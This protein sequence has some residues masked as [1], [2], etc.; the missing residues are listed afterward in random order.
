MSADESLNEKSLS[1]LTTEIDQ[2][3]AALESNELPLEEA[4]RRY[5]QGMSLLKVAQSKLNAAEQQVRLLD[6]ALN[7]DED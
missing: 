4:I 2:A 1:E 3:V 5:E 7:K 6:P